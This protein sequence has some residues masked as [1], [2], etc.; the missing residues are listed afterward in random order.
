MKEYE[1]PL[2]SI[3]ILDYNRPIESDLL[4]KSLGKNAAFKYELVYVS[5][6]GEQDYVKKYYDEGH[7]DILVLSRDNGGTGLGTKL[8]FKAASGKYVLYVQVDQWLGAKIDS[9]QIESL[10]QILEKD[11][12]IFY[13]DLAGNQGAGNYSERAGLVN[14]ER[15]LNVPELEKAYGGPGKYAHIQWSENGVQEHIRKN[16]LGILIGPRIFG[17]NGKNS[18]RELPC[19]GVILLTTDEKR[20]Y[21]LKTPK[22]KVDHPNLKLTDQEWDLILSGSWID[23]TIPEGH[24]DSSFLVWKEPFNSNQL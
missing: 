6:G 3:V 14:R 10:C 21:I 17:D 1:K 2:L 4:L 8:G 15:Y 16:N 5:N 11:P 24:K 7:I 23:G 20:L 22:E 12:N 18:I 19:G 9:S 13:I